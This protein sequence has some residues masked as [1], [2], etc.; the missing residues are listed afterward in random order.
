MKFSVPV[1]FFLIVLAGCG[2][3]DTVCPYNESSVVAPADEIANLSDSL[4]KYNITASQA[5]PGFFYKINSQGSGASVANLCTVV[6]V[7]YKGMFFDGSIFDSTA[8]NQTASFQLGEVITG[9][10][11]A[12][13]LVN[14]G[15]DIDLYIPPSLGYGPNTF[16]D[17]PGNSYLVFNVHVADI[18]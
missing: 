8:N 17:I 15:G 16:R 10:Q 12:I 2:K 18:Q 9:W 1:L 6:T 11:K 4:A 13:P 3:T 7:S 14:K 5:A